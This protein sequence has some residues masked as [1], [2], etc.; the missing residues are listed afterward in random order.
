M[1]LYIIHKYLNIQSKFKDKTS[2]QNGW[3]ATSKPF[4]LA[5]YPQSNKDMYTIR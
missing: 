4:E 1:C 2:N 5:V 3:L